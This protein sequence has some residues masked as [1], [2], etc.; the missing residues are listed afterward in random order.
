MG[1]DSIE[2]NSHSMEMAC[3]LKEK[4]LKIYSNN[5]IK[6]QWEL[7][8]HSIG[9]RWDAYW[10][11][12]WKFTHEYVEKIITYEKDIDLKGHPFIPLDFITN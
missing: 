3:I 10:W 6:I 12:Y 8:S 11:M 2:L 5:W 9:K 4:I 7:N 1:E